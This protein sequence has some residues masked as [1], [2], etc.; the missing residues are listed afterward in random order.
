MAQ[1][2]DVAIAQ[3]GEAMEGLITLTTSVDAFANWWLTVDTTLSIL[4]TAVSSIQR[5]RK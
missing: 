1:D 4:E 3:L 2:L 5:C